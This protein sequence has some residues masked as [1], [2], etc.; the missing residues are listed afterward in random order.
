MAT[1]INKVAL[2][3]GAS[4]GIGNAIA[5]RLANDG[6]TIIAHY[7]NSKAGIDT[8]V[9]GINKAGGKAFAVRA[10]LSLANAAD[11]LI[12]EVDNVLATNKLG[13]LDILVN[14]AGIAPWATLEQTDEATFNNI[15]AVNV[16]APFFIIKNALSRLNDG[17]RIINLTSAVTRV[18][19][20]GIM[21]YA[22]S[23]GSIDTLTLQLAAELGARNIT[24]NGVAPGG[25]ETDMSAWLST[26][27]GEAQAVG[28]QA[29]KRKGQA[30]DIARVVGFLAGPDSA[31][32]TGQILEASGGLKL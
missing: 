11:T 13:K 15:Y 27:E 25:I 12:A 4:R 22:S 3:T 7:S 5:K 9:D 23:K 19:F 8:L 29:L 10:D 18:Y 2:V 21:A 16:R 31:W 32:I 24:V 14:N 28:M 26:P 20:P 30:D 17:G 6:A 1:L